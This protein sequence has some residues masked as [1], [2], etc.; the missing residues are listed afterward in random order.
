MQSV[1]I[2]ENTIRQLN[3]AATLRGMDINAYAE[4]LLAISLAALRETAP[5]DQKTHHAMEFS[6]VAPTGRTA[7]E[8]DAELEEARSEW[9]NQSAH[10]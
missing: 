4:E 10:L 8:I 7:A 1:T 9:P 5:V 3:H 6:A 2:S